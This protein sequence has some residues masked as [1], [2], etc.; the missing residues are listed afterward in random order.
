MPDKPFFMYLA[1]GATHAPHH[2]PSEGSARCQGRFDR[3]ARSPAGPFICRTASRS[4]AT[5]SRASSGFTSR[6]P[7]PFRP[8]STK[9]ELNS[10][11]TAEASARAEPSHI[12]GDKAGEGR[13]EATV[14]MIYSGDETCDVRYNSGTP[15]S[16]DYTS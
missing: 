12:D 15:V 5:T 8:A 3:A 6:H 9:S 14:P 7:R 4:T 11:T 13:V 16:E 1:P 2:V 10:L